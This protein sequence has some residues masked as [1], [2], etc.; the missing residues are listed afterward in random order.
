MSLLY[1]S[2]FWGSLHC[3][4]FSTDATE[5]KYLILESDRKVFGLDYDKENK[6]KSK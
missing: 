6:N 4:Y 5:P 1:W 3:S 2:D